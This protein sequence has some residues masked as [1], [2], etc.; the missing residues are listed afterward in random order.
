M[1]GFSDGKDESGKMLLRRTFH[2]EDIWEAGQ[3]NLGYEC[4]DKPVVSKG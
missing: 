3:G 4:F 2:A 1:C